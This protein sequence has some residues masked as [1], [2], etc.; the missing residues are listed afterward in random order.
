[1]G[2]TPLM[3]PDILCIGSVHWDIIGRTSRPID[4]G[5]DVPGRISR[6]PGG[7]AL[8]IAMA[9]ARCGLRPAVL[10]AIGRDPEGE[11]L[12][13]ACAALGVETAFSHR[14]GHLPTDCYLAIEDSRSLVAAIA[15][16]ATLESSG[17]SILDPLK[18][19]RLGSASR[20]WSG[21]VAL[22]GNLTQALVAEIAS[23]PIL[24]AA[25]LRAA[26]ASPAKAGNLA[27]LLAH[28]GVTFHVNLEEANLLSG[29]SCA[30][31]PEAA[32]ALVAAG[33]G[34][35]LV[36]D[37]PRTVAD[38]GRGLDLLVG[39][40]PQV[41]VARIT[42]AGD[43]FMAAHLAAEYRGASRETALQAALAAAA[44]HVSGDI[45]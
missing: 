3:A 45:A 16:A 13:A 22:D 31:A 34:R 4:R 42:G 6:T 21:L 43:A 9:V 1:M 30:T 19:G 38:A 23:A 28:P 11:A 12:V 35:A 18:D 7:V 33:A 39:Q 8:N 32:M 14:P 24:A 2:E 15:S 5:E 40:P 37:G 36:T 20:P 29:R 44:A 25:R 10:T 41:R 17:A 27:P 26:P